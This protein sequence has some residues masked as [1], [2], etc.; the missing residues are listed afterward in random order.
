MGLRPS[1]ALLTEK[2][3]VKSY[4]RAPG[5]DQRPMMVPA[6]WGFAIIISHVQAVPVRAIGAGRSS[7]L[8]ARYQGD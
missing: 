8:D 2:C 7:S 6:A 3:S 4:V 5:V 1:R